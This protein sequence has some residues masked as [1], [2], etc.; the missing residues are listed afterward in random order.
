MEPD[1]PAADGD[2]YKPLP[3]SRLPSEVRHHTLHD[4]INTRLE[5]TRTRFLAVETVRF[6]P[7]RSVA[8]PQP[9]IASIPTNR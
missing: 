9:S 1:P 7:P 6:W 3:L 2:K 4:R 5:P 8:Q